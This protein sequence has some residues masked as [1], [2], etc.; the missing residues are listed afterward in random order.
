MIYK[1]F[2]YMNVDDKDKNQLVTLRGV[3]VRTNI[4][5]IDI[6]SRITGNYAINT[7]HIELYTQTYHE[8]D[9]DFYIS[10]KFDKVEEASFKGIIKCENASI[11]ADTY[12]EFVKLYNE[13]ME[14]HVVKELQYK[15]FDNKKEIIIVME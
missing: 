8:Y 7:L 15:H 10:L 12:M 14:E 5:M 2:D 11:S 3:A 9:D 1:K 6:T 13:A 4:D